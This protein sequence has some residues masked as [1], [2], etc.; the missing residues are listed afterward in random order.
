MFE[1]LYMQF[2]RAKESDSKD[3]KSLW[4]YC[5]EKPDEAFFQWFFSKIYEHDNVV[6][7]EEQGN[8]AAAVHLR[9][10]E[11][12][13]RGNSLL[14]DYAVGLA[15]HPAAR[16]NGIGK[17][18]LKNA[19]RLSCSNG[20]STMILMPSDASFYQPLGC[21]F[22][23]HQWKRETSP[24]WL[25]KVGSKPSWVKTLSSPDEWELL[26]GIYRTFI[27]GR[28][29]FSIREESSWRRLIEGQLEEGYIAVVGDET[30]AAGYLF[31][32]VNDTHL[33]AGEMAYSSNKGR[34]GL[35]FFM[36]GHRGSIARCSWFEPLDDRSFYYWPNGAEH[37]YIENKTFPFMMCRII[38]PVAVMDGMPCDKDLDGE[39]SFQLVDSVLSENNGIYMLNAENGYIHALQ[40]DIFYNLRIH[41]EDMAG[42]DLDHHIPEPAFCMN[43]PALN[44]L[45]FGASDF[46]ELLHRDMITWLT[47][48]ES[49]REKV[50]RF[51]M[52]VWNKQ[53]NWINE[54][55]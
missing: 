11:I 35:Y 43:I 8:I 45:V 9:P 14:V 30:G 52:K 16:G 48:D 37:T 33:L 26:D 28:N 27:K 47:T 2:R 13:L 51:M 32:G 53:A 44:E 12:C 49:K 7:A 22:Y 20:N 41:V 54:W 40:D 17:K 21:S 31:Y 18:L 4:A 24:E 25:G 42:V 55:Y 50:T 3:I 23:V 38:D 6:V 39:F 29:G 19:F 15:T 1:G 36:A 10:Y 5:F 34:E 46:K